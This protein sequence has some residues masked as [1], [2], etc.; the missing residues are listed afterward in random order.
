MNA[1]AEILSSRVRA[2]I[3]RLLFGPGAERLHMRELERQSGCVIGTIQTELKKLLRL[4]L[5][6]CRRDGNRLYY[7]ANRAHPLYAEIR[8]L[9]LKTSGLIPALSQ[10]LAPVAGVRVAFVF[11]S[12]A[13]QEEGAA[14]DIDL[15]V[16]GQPG[17]RQLTTLL[18]GVAQQVGREI[19]PHTMA[20]EEFVQRRAQGD[21]FVTQLLASPRLFVR[22][23]EDELAKLGG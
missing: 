1:L 21:H 2:E 13:R 5:V 12:L 18:S 14:S 3:F 16:I 7:Q 8:G 20:V 6:S 15:L 11:G 23:D 4:E 19:N 17:L 9:V 10:A 22:G